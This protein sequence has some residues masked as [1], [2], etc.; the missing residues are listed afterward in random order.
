[1]YSY[2]LF[3]YYIHDAKSLVLQSDVTLP[4]ASAPV[5][6]PRSF[7]I[8]RHVYNYQIQSRDR[9]TQASPVIAV[10]S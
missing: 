10:L 3:I 9:T 4:T 6:K 8:A 2:M 5:L 1:M 7:C